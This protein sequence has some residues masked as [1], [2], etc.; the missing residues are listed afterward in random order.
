MSPTLNDCPGICQ[1]TACTSDAVVVGLRC[2][3]ADVC[4]LR[5]CGIFEGARVRVVDG[6]NGVV[7]DTHGVR[8]ALGRSLATA[9]SVRPHAARP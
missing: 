3:A 1:L 4:R 2:S 6:A 8:L 7:L 5:A 9:I